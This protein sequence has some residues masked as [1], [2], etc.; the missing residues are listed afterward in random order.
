MSGAQGLYFQLGLSDNSRVMAPRT[1]IW[2]S[3]LGYL[4]I[5]ILAAVGIYISVNYYSPKQLGPSGI[6]F[7]F[8]GVLVLI[9]SLVG[10]LSFSWKMRKA[11]NRETPIQYLLSATRSGFLLGLT[12]TAL[13]ALSSLRSLSM[14]DIILFILT[15]LLI[16]GYFRTRRKTRQ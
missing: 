8:I 7:W 15:I 6:T 1:V 9:W 4:L 14:R 2:L 10:F 13:L 3:L 16:E 5:F 12:A 11:D